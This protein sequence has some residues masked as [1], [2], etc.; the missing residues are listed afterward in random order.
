MLYIL[1][2]LSVT[3]FNYTTH[4]ICI[5]SNSEGSKKLPDDGRPLPKHVE[6]SIYNKVVVESVHSVGHFYYLSN[7]FNIEKTLIWALHSYAGLCVGVMLLNAKFCL[8]YISH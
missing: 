4:S 6:A 5:S 2:L 7:G 8:I 3:C 1:I